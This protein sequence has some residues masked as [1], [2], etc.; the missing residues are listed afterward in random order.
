MQLPQHEGMSHRQNKGY[1]KI[2]RSYRHQLFST[3]VNHWIHKNKGDL[4]MYH[5][6]PPALTHKREFSMLQKHMITDGDSP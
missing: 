1:Q 6:L 3:K 5:S 4:T 2:P